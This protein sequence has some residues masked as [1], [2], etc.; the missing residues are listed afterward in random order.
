MQTQSVNSQ[1]SDGVKVDKPAAGNPA[2]ISNP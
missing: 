1:L 2:H